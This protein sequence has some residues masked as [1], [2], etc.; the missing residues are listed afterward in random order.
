MITFD[1]P[2]FLFVMKITVVDALKTVIDPELHANIVDL[3]L[4]YHVKV[5]NIN[6]CILI[7]M[8]LSS[9]NCPMS[10]S[11]L[12]AVKNCIIRTFPDYQAEVSLVWE[13]EWNYRTIPEAGLRKLRGL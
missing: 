6:K 4:I 8:T 9:R 2:E 3:G 11:I 10:E 13:P 12:S 1:I 7:E 5:D